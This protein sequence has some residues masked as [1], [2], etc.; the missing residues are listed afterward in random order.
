MMVSISPLRENMGVHCIRDPVRSCLIFEQ[1]LLVRNL[2]KRMIP[3]RCFIWD[4]SDHRHE[5]DLENCQHEVNN[6]KGFSNVDV[7]LTCVL[8]HKDASI[9]LTG[10]TVQSST[11]SHPCDCFVTF[12]RLTSPKATFCILTLLPSGSSKLSSHCCSVLDKLI[13]TRLG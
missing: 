7:R 1:N 5:R 4:A 3:R 10:S 13:A 12:E 11:A 9:N 6:S 8:S 2:S